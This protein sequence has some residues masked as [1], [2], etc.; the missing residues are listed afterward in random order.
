MA[1]LSGIELRVVGCS[2]A[3]LGTSIGTAVELV[4]V[5]GGCGVPRIACSCF[6]VVD[7]GVVASFG[8]LRWVGVSCLCSSGLLSAIDSSESQSEGLVRRPHRRTGVC[9]AAAGV[10]VSSYRSSPSFS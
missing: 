7:A 4:A 10:D 5:S 8:R 9:G 6:G 3:V 1:R 2:P